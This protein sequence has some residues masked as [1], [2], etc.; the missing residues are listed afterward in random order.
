MKLRY[1]FLCRV[2]LFCIPRDKKSV[3]DVALRKRMLCLLASH[4]LEEVKSLLKMGV[5]A[6]LASEFHRTYPL[7][8]RYLFCTNSVSPV[9][10]CF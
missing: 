8:S 3:V 10:G 1:P 2:N 4:S 5:A 9:R 6:A 7:N